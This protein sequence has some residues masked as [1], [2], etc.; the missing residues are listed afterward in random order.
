MVQRAT[1]SDHPPMDSPTPP[2]SPCSPHRSSTCKPYLRSKTPVTYTAKRS[3]NQGILRVKKNNV[4]PVVRQ[5]SDDSKQQSLDAE[6]ARCRLTLLPPPADAQ[7]AL[8]PP[9]HQLADSQWSG[10]GKGGLQQ[11][12]V[13]LPWYPLKP[14]GGRAVVTHHLLGAKANQGENHLGRK[15]AGQSMV[16]ASMAAGASTLLVAP[17]KELPKG[18]VR[19]IDIA[20]RY[21]NALRYL[22]G[23]S[24]HQSLQPQQS[25]SVIC[26]ATVYSGI[27]SVYS[28]KR[29]RVVTSHAKDV[30]NLCTSCLYFLFFVFK[31]KY[32]Y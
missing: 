26:G 16:F 8:G 31:L 7:G 3:E 2:S 30:S 29:R 18:T 22:F 11:R 25:W 21:Q 19:V 1:V 14:A 4:S 9:L 32:I 20:R 13:Q 6:S 10:A 15:A 27:G 12:A 24:H 5:S 17:R 23:A 28:F